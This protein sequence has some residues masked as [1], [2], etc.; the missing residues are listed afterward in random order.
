MTTGNKGRHYDAG[1]NLHWNTPAKVRDGV[2]E[3]FKGPPDL[4]PC[5]NDTSIMGAKIEYKLPHNDGLVDP[6]HITGEKPTKV[7]FN[8]PYGRC[9]LR[10]DKQVILSQKEWSAGRKLW[11]EVESSPGYMLTETSDGAI[12]FPEELVAKGSNLVISDEYAKRF[13]SST[14]KDWVMR[15]HREGRCHSVGLIPAATGASHFQKYVLGDATAI[16]FIA[17]RVTFLGNVTG[18][19]PMDCCL[20][21]WGPDVDGFIGVFSKLGT[22]VV[23]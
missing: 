2:H 12:W 8:P 14:I 17:G 23:P 20:P 13:K 18:P 4:D 6:W 15:A 11:E 3:F 22:V 10:D 9:Y 16:C 1:S 21:Y 7:F 5:A 19:A